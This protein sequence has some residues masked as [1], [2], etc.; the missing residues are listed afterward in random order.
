V[1]APPIDFLGSV[2]W[3][4]TTVIVAIVAIIG[5]LVYRYYLEPPISRQF[6]SARWSKGPVGFIQ[7]DANQVHLVT[8]KVALPEGILYTIRGFFLQ[9][10]AP[11]I[12]LP[13][14]KLKIDVV[15][16]RADLLEQYPDLAPDKLEKLLA[17]HIKNMSSAET[18][19][20]P[21]R[22]KEEKENG[23]TDEQTAAL[24]IALQTPTLAGFGRA[25]FFGYDGAPLVS[26]LKTLAVA[27]NEALQVVDRKIAEG[28]VVRTV[29]RF[30]GHADLRIMKEIIPA[31][32]S[33]TQLGNLYKWAVAKG[34]E[35][36]GKDQMKL[37]Y[38]AIAAAI[39]IACLGIVAFLLINGGG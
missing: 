7:D 36:S 11:Y 19:R 20:G 30:I 4:F 25:V 1:A 16:L 34:Y 24:G 8:S 10:R 3:Q 23:L 26:N 38:I 2:F 17:Q 37:I 5:F 9:G 12:P 27:S 6:M 31:T 29:E 33:R 21:G 13:T 14:E 28:K 32:I 39:P 18:K 35:K 15:K 22:P